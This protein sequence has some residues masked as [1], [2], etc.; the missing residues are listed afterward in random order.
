MQKNIKIAYIG[1]GSKQWARVFMSDLAVSDG[2]SGQIALYD[3]DLEAAQRNAAIGER[4]NQNPAAKSHFKYTVCPHLDDALEGA[5]FVIISIL[6]GTFREMRSDV[7]AH[8]TL[9]RRI[10][11][12]NP[13]YLPQRLGVEFHQSHEHL[14]QNP[15][16]CVPPDQSL[17][18]LP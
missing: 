2:L 10:R 17:R 5:D 18:L 9:L 13:G 1:G 3:I 16:R 15:V 4:I 8:R 7:H 6:P 11:P 14:R 12:E